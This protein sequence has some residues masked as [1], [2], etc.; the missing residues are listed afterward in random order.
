VNKLSDL[1]IFTE[2]AKTLL[3]K[4]PESDMPIDQPI[5]YRALQEL[6]IK[7]DMAGIKGD[8]KSMPARGPHGWLAW[9]SSIFKPDCEDAFNRALVDAVSHM[10]SLPNAIIY[11]RDQIRHQK[12]LY[13]KIF[14]IIEAVQ[15]TYTF[16][17]AQST[18]H[19]PPLFAE[20][21]VN[22]KA[23]ALDAQSQSTKNQGMVNCFHEHIMQG[24][25][26]TFI[27]TQALHK[28]AVKILAENK[29]DHTFP[30]Y[31]TAF[32]DAAR[33]DVALQARVETLYAKTAPTASTE[34]LAEEYVRGAGGPLIANDEAN[35][36]AHQAQNLLHPLKPIPGHLRVAAAANA[37]LNGSV[38][39]PPT[40]CVSTCPV[41]SLRRAPGLLP[42]PTTGLLRV[43]T[44][45]SSAVR[46]V[47]L[48]A[49]SFRAAPTTGTI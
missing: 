29:Q 42:S 34:P 47:R 24:K 8:P 41:Q 3:L 6:R 48:P 9:L 40:P 23:S 5:S 7:A 1:V 36:R 46:P 14:K 18:D 30:N 45:S 16:L 15:G 32:Q 10:P 22:P 28:D 13:T 39:P 11:S 49:T 2:E 38:S 4:Y 21:P 44:T 37:F 27:Y 26:F 19:V 20:A 12:D 17:T 35:I 25:G 31:L 43:S 33:G